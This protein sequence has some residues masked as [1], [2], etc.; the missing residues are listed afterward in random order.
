MIPWSPSE[1]EGKQRQGREK[2]QW[3]CIRV[4]IT[5]SGSWLNSTGDAL[6]RNI[7]YALVLRHWEQRLWG[8]YP[9]SS[10]FTSSILPG[11]VWHLGESWGSEKVIRYSRWEMQLLEMGQCQC[12]G[13]SS[14]TASLL[15]WARGYVGK[16][17]TVSA[18]QRLLAGFCLG[19]QGK[20]T[21]LVFLR[22]ETN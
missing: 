7:E 18:T 14:G 2:I 3:G 16:I 15:R 6:K 1:E 17:S 19:C 20:E 5:T 12:S 10:P 4:W 8:N 22:K 13:K 11:C 9:F 21:K